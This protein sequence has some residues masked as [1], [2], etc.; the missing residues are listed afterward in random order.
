MRR[1][2]IIAETGQNFST[3]LAAR[4]VFITALLGVAALFRQSGD[5]LVQYIVL[6]AANAMLSLGCWEW[7]RKRRS[8]VSLR[9]FALTAAVVLDT[10]ALH[11]AGG[12]D[13]EF[14]FLYFFSIGSAGFLVG[15]VGSVWI[16]T[17]ST[18]GMLWLYFDQSGGF[19]AEH[20]LHAFVFATNFILTALLTSYVFDKLSERERTHQRTLGKL[21][22]TR[23]DTQAILDS[24]GTG[25]VVVNIERKVLYS[26][27]AGR[28]ILGMS[29]ASK[30]ADLEALFEPGAQMGDALMGLLSDP[31]PE[32]RSEITLQCENGSKPIGFSASPLRDP[33]GELRGYIIL[34][35]DLSRLKEIERVERER[36]RLAA[37]GRLSRDLAHEIR[38]PLATVRGC[39]EMIERSDCPCTEHAPYLELALRESDRLNNLLRDFLTFA[40]LDAPHKEKGDLVALIR[41]HI[42]EKR[43]GVVF[44]DE[45]PASLEVEF[46]AD[47]IALVVNAILLSLYEWA[48]GEGE[49]RVQQP[50]QRTK[51]IR[52]L[53]ANQ[54]IPPGIKDAVFEPFSGVQKSSNGLALPTAMRAMHAHGGQLTLDTEPGVGTWFELA[55]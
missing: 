14:I 20:A 28:T 38:N 3:F 16:A 18:L 29:R 22:Q 25:V 6:F 4:L 36:E 42:P 26:N 48:E 46:D 35:S 49:I 31:P 43:N 53:L 45:L 50:V 34:F 54:T 40:R 12:P 32:S 52:F 51:A 30:A 41:S 55:I 10:L 13:S 19:L 44:T 17:L 11:F 39:V 15:L 33:A 37:I 21:E 2:R 7:F 8:D 23:L 9:W 24:L 47:Q 1:M 5:S 27:P